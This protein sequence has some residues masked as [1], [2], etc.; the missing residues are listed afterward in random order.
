MAKK[1]PSVDTSGFSFATST[2]RE[3][4][5]AKMPNLK[6]MASHEP[7]APQ[8]IRKFPGRDLETMAQPLKKKLLSPNRSASRGRR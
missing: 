5:M 7:A 1:I 8:P 6:P 3:P 4:D 2:V